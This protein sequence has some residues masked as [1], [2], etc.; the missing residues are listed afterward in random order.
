M[1]HVQIVDLKIIRNRPAGT[2]DRLGM[3][4][5]TDG[6]SIPVYWGYIA[7]SRCRN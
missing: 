3:G 1:V 2:S 4:M 5:K 7:M 6:R